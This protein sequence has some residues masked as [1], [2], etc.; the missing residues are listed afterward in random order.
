MNRHGIKKII[1]IMLFLFLLIA[2]VKIFQSIKVV[3]NLMNH[4]LDL[5][6][7]QLGENIFSIVLTCIGIIIMCSIITQIIDLKEGK[8]T[9][10]RISFSEKHPRINFIIGLVLFVMLS[11]LVGSLVYNL[12]SYFMVLLNYFVVWSSSVTSK[13]DIVVIVALIT[14]SVS[15]TS[16][17]IS[18]IFAKIMDYRK[19][20]KE[21][22]SQKREE[23]YGEFVEMIYKIQ[24]NEKNNNS[25]TEEMMI[26]DLAKFSRKITL[27][28]SKNVV[29]KWIKFRERSAN[30]DV[31]IDHLF[32]LEDILNEMRK[33]L[34]LKKVKKGNLL[35]FFI[36]DIEEVIKKKKMK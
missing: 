28:G 31:D 14:G 22:L 1:I 32:V 24:Q 7:T 19:N 21:Y 16:V 4:V 9:N 20:R 17:I 33:D 2:R 34:G 26:D 15:I 29:M 6:K 30:P 12:L 8:D 36:N 10:L 25:Y 23:P 11:T 27:W 3:I 35:G 5:L 13:M 18:S